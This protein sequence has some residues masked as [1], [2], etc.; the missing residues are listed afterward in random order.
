MSTRKTTSLAAA[1]L[2]AGALLPAACGYRLRGTGNALFS[3]QGIRKLSVPVFKN[4]TTRFELDI[5][6]TRAVINEFVARGRVEVSD[7]EAADAVLE[8]EVSDFR[9]TPIGFSAQ[10]SSADRYSINI[11]AAIRIRNLRTKK[12]IYENP[13]Y[14]WQA[15]YEVPQG[16]DFESS[17][18]EALDR[19]AEKFAQQLVITILEGF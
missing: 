16:T 7:P 13:S 19:I 15:D 3:G 12:V 9:A 14:A 1:V 2:L 11:V 18:T 10:Q 8:G 5:K 17:E 6:L 4:N